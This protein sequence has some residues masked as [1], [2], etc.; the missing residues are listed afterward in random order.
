[1]ITPSPAYGQLSL[2]VCQSAT[3]HCNLLFSSVNRL[4]GVS[5]RSYLTDGVDDIRPMG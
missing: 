5:A 1:M 3:L 2:T 4:R